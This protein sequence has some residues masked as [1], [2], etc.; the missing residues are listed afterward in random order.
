MIQPLNIS[1][2]GAEART[3]PIWIGPAL[4]DKSTLWMPKGIKNV[5]IITDDA[6]KKFYASRLEKSLKEAGYALSLVL[7]F[8]EGEAS[9]NRQ[10]KEHLE[11][12]LLAQG[13]HRETCILALGGGVVG[14]IAGFVAATYMRG[15]AYIYLPTTLLAMV[16]SSIGGKTGINTPQGKNLIGAFWQPLAV[17]SDIHCLKTLPEKQKMSG[18]VEA[19]KLFLI[20]TPPPMAESEE[21]DP[22]V[23][24]S[25]NLEGLMKGDEPALIQLIHQAVKLKAAI[26]EQDETERGLRTLL[27]CGHTIGHALEKLSGYQLLHG[28]AVAL[29]L[30]VEAKIA[31]LMGHLDAKSYA[32]IKALLNRL[33]MTSTALKA[34]DVEAVIQCTYAD[35]K[36]HGEG[37]HYVL[38]QNLGCA[39]VQGKQFSHP[40]PDA[41]VK[42]AF[43]CIDED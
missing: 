21:G 13:C 38:L 30:L 32:R 11:D 35:K 24:F 25:E 5:V 39:Y 8:V 19:L 9:K 41:M 15:I 43:L 27:N 3:I 18:L 34:F 29:G 17:I 7:S 14:D 36:N 6:V 2:P 12:A 16:D 28:Y 26:V 37:V 20:Y 22:L 10:T 4:L 42:R 23:F 31:Q 33:N 1:I 40:I